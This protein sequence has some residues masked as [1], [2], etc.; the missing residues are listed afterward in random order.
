MPQGAHLIRA[1]RPPLLL[2]ET[3]N[4]RPKQSNRLTRNEFGSLPASS[5]PTVGSIFMIPL[6]CCELERARKGTLGACRKRNCKCPCSPRGPPLPDKT[7]QTPWEPGLLV[8]AAN[9]PS[10]LWLPVAPRCNSFLLKS[11]SYILDT[12]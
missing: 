11:A 1:G 2:S 3:R 8:E 7:G 12:Y 5:H 9:P 4:S 10:A 6:E